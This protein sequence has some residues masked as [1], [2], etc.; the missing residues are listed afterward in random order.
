MP[1][2]TNAQGTV[3]ALTGVSRLNPFEQLATVAGLGWLG[4]AV[5]GVW[6]I[7]GGEWPYLVYGV[8]LLLAAALSVATA[9]WAIHVDDRVALR[10]GGLGIGVLAV[11]STAVAWASPLWMTL[12]AITFAVWAAAAGDAMRPGLAILTAAQLIGLGAMIVAIR[13]ELGPQNSYGDYPAGFGVGL[14]VAGIGSALGLAVLAR[15]TRR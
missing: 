10:W 14:L 12:L 1:S 8:T 15:S 6:E 4:V 5:A 2:P 11:A 7:A 3:Q 13:A 9:W